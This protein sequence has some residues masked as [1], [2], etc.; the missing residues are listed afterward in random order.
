ML[1]EDEDESAVDEVDDIDESSEDVDDM[2]DVEV[3]DVLDA[4]CFR[5]F[6][7]EL[8]ADAGSIETT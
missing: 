5:V 8:A 6:L 7:R 3:I 1:V 4:I 2:D